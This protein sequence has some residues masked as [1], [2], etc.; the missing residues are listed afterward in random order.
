MQADQAAVPGVLR[1]LSHVAVVVLFLSVPLAAALVAVRFAPPSRVEIAGQPVAVK[2]VLGQD[3]SRLQGGAL[4]RP[5]HAHVSALGSNRRGRQRR[6]NRLIPSDKQTRRYLVA[7]WDDPK[8]EISRIQ[9]A[10]RAYLVQWSLIGFLTA[11]WSRA[12]WRCWCVNAGD[13]WRRIAPSRLRS[14]L[15]TTGACARVSSS[16]LSPVL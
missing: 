16:R 6:L 13:D 4:I 10:A 12:A 1:R 7:L 5:E 14:S 15:P 11:R 8:P 9:G 2:P 3:T